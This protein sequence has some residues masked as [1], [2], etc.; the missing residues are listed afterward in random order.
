MAAGPFLCR[1]PYP[2][3]LNEV[4]W[5]TVSFAKAQ[6][7]HSKGT[8]DLFSHGF[9]AKKE[10]EQAEVSTLRR[11]VH[12]QHKAEDESL[13][14]SIALTAVCPLLQHDPCR[15]V[16]PDMHTN[17]HKYTC[18]HDAHTCTHTRTQK[19]PGPKAATCTQVQHASRSGASSPSGSGLLHEH[20]L[21][22]RPKTCCHGDQRHA[23]T[24]C[25]GDQRQR[26]VEPRC[27]AAAAQQDAPPPFS[28]PVPAAQQDTTASLPAQQL[29]CI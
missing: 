6:A 9:R 27:R 25:H 15:R 7:L 29:S 4:Q 8:Q 17:T 23:L 3:T 5:K 1:S 19:R 26:G 12:S 13:R 18:K 16:H 11:E 24:C 28:L 14:G 21:P 10:G 20:M 22:R 2:S